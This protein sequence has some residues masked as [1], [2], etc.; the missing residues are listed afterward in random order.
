M[1]ETRS[2]LRNA[3]LIAVLILSLTLRLQATQSG[4]SNTAFATWCSGQPSA[5]TY[6]ISNN[7]GVTVA[8]LPAGS[9]KCTI[10]GRPHNSAVCMKDDELEISGVVD[11][12]GT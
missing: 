11:Q 7:C 2:F 6:T 3:M 8:S 5:G 10:G 12:N 9:D 4:G 1:S